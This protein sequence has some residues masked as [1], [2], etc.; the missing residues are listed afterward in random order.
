MFSAPSIS[1]T[2]QGGFW[3]QPERDSHF[4]P[5]PSAKFQALGFE[6]EIETYG[7][8]VATKWCCAYSKHSF[9]LVLF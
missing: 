3:V 6:V 2:A 4:L 7:L 8:C 1:Y 9:F 5:H